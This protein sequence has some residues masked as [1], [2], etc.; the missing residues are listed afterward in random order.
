MEILMDPQKYN[1]GEDTDDE[2]RTLLLLLLIPDLP[3]AYHMVG[4]IFVIIFLNAVHVQ[5]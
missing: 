4:T 1:C 2:N 3:A 5:S